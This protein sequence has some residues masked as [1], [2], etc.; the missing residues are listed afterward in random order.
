LNIASGTQSTVGGGENNVASG[1]LSTASGGALNCAGGTLSWAGGRQAK[2]RPALD[3]VTGICSGL[4]SYPG[5]TGGDAGTFIWADNQPSNFVSSGQNQFLI[6]TSGGAVITANSA[7]NDP[8]GNRLR[9]DGTLRVDVLGTAAA[10][11]LCRNASNQIASCSS[12]ARYKSD[13]AD[14]ELG[15]ATALRLHA[16][17]YR[18]KDTGA[19]DVG[20]VAE[21]IAAI[22]ERLV[23]R[24]AKGEIEGVKYDRLTAVLANAVQELAARGSLA[25]EELSRVDAENAAMRLEQDRLADE[26]EALQSRLAA[27]EAR[28][29]LAGGEGR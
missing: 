3:P 13:I 23:T 1:N 21:E 8:A 27:I 10:T 2:V 6:R 5:G 18:W 7:T 22:D 25:A 24:N 4:G 11:T 14:L 16:V 20:F 29:G 26:N 19:A 9:V 12:S 15:L 28:L 17:G